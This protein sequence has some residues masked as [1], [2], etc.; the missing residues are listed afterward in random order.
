MNANGIL[1]FTSGPDAGE[2]WGE[3]GGE[4]LYHAS[5]SPD[6]YNQLL[7]K[8]GFKVLVHK[9]SDPDCGEATVWLAQLRSK[10]A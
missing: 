9:I 2:V 8:H 5:L 6:E 4:N 10:H 3:N 7:E 1:L